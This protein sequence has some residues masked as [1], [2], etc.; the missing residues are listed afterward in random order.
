MRSFFTFLLFTFYSH[1]IYVK[2]ENYYSPGELELRLGEFVDYY[3]NNRYH[4]SINNLT[5][6]DV[7]YGRDY[8]ILKQR[9]LIKTRTMKQKKK[10]TPL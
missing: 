6:A 2:L 10:N 8:H 3:N 9:E 4:E 5:P 7:C 1:N